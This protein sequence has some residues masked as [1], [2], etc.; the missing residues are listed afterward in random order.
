MRK[1]KEIE[2]RDD[3]RTSGALSH[4]PEKLVAGLNPAIPVFR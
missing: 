3:M 1:N 2:R 4:D